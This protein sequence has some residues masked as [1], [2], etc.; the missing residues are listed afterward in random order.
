MKTWLFLLLILISG[1]IGEDSSNGE[2]NDNGRGEL[3]RNLTFIALTPED[4]GFV[5]W[6]LS[7]ENL[8]IDVYERRFVKVEGSFGA[9]SRLVNRVH[10][11]PDSETAKADFQ[12]VAEHLETQISTTKPELG[13]EAIMWSDDQQTHLLFRRKDVI[14]ELEYTGTDTFEPGFL[15]DQGRRVDSKII[16]QG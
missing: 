8:S 4:L 6:V 14:V 11:Y 9:I 10:L 16:D 13:E 12:M 5:G 15:I 3:T 1:C 2:I 7:S